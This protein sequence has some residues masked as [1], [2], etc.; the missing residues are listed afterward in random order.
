MSWRRYRNA[1]TL[2][3]IFG[4]AGLILTMASVILWLNSLS[5]LMGF[6]VY[7]IMIFVFLWLLSKIGLAIHNT[8]IKSLNQVIGL[9]LIQFALF[10]IIDY[11]SCGIAIVTVTGTWLTSHS[12]T[13]CS[14]IVPTIYTESEDGVI[15][16]LWANVINNVFIDRILTYGITPAALAILGGLLMRGRKASL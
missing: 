14:G 12:A 11:T 8:S 6:L 2:G 10:I 15:W 13:S 4:I 1:I 16:Y 5:V 3:I 9:W 7:E